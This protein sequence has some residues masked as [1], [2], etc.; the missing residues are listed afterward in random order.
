MASLDQ[1]SKEI[2]RIGVEIAERSDATV[3]AAAIAIDQAVVTATPVDTGR[4]RSN[5]IAEVDA[6]SR[7]VREP[8]VPGS[9]GSTGAENVRASTLD[10]ARKIAR[11]NGDRNIFIAISNNLGYINSLNSGSSQQAPAG[12]VQF[13]V[14]A[15]AGVVRKARLVK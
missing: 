4:A 6:P 8:F 9:L 13:A 14:Q 2:T 1:F 5:W 3:R 7:I 10:A 15:A 12:F 11:Y